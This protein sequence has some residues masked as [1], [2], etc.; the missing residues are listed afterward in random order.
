MSGGDNRGG[1]IGGLFATRQRMT[2]FN[3]DSAAVGP[4]DG[5]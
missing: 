2:E 1:V 3:E 4:G 5:W